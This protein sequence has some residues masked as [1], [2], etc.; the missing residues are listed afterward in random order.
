MI[1]V[2]FEI[3]AVANIGVTKVS[4]CH[5]DIELV[6]W[7]K[8]PR[9]S[10]LLPW[11]PN[12]SYNRP[13]SGKWVFSSVPK[14]T[15][16]L[17]DS[18]VKLFDRGVADSAGRLLFNA[19]ITAA[20]K[21]GHVQWIVLSTSSRSWGLLLASISS[22]WPP[23]TLQWWEPRD[24]LLRSEFLWTVL[25]FGVLGKGKLC[26]LYFP[27]NCQFLTQWKPNVSARFSV[28]PC[29]P[30]SFPWQYLWLFNKWILHNWW[31]KW[32]QS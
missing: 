28:M 9:I 32:L 10:I 15:V 20:Q 30:A 6:L 31:S 18:S 12:N 17:K 19:S 8:T 25:H 16:P 26:C 29:W 4:C 24:P 5:A 23:A 11:I 27:F 1:L 13:P 22:N 21:F 3:Y 2:L 14:T 7:E